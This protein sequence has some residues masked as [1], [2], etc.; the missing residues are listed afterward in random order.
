MALR[1]FL[2]H[3]ALEGTEFLEHVAIEDTERY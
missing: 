2:E 3:I 1:E